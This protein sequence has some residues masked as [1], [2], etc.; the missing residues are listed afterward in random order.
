FVGASHIP[1]GYADVL[2]NM[3]ITRIMEHM[4]E[5]PALVEAGKRGEFGDV[6]S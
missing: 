1:D 4:D 2:R 3:G 5:L 6:Q